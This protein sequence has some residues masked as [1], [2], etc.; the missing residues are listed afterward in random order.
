M[1]PKRLVILGSTGSIGRSCMDAVEAHPGR[2]SVRALAAYSNVNLL[3]QQYKSVKP[4]YVCIVDVS[5]ESD[6][7]QRLKGEPVEG[8]RPRAPIWP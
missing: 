8:I 5:K 2:F 7:R 6:L 3:V 1:V 4:G